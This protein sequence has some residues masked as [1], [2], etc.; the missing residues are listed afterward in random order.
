LDR[1]GEGQL[2]IPIENPGER[3]LSRGTGGHQG[4][5]E[6]EGVV[7]REIARGKFSKIE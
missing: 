6:P 4:T 1:T 3:V 7:P 2:K 5:G